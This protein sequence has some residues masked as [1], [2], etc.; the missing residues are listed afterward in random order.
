M[1]VGWQNRD[2][3]TLVLSCNNDG[4]G[5]CSSYWQFD[6]NYDNTNGGD[7]I[8][9]DEHDRLGDHHVQ[10]GEPNFS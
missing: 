5:C 7:D 2:H 1:V 3:V 6:D 10:L 9:D 8:Y 4:D